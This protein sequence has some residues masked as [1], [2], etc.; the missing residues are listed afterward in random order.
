[1]LLVRGDLSFAMPDEPSVQYRGF[2]SASHAPV[3]NKNMATHHAEASCMEMKPK[4]LDGI[5]GGGHL[6]LGHV[7]N[8]VCV[9]VVVKIEVVCL[10]IVDVTRLMV[11]VVAGRR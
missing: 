3:M 7:L 5:L 10:D 11:V 9:E 6:P 8:V 2:R 4:A 1:V